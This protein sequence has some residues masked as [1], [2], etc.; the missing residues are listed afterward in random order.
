MKTQ[1]AL[2]GDARTLDTLSRFLAQCEKLSPEPVAPP[3]AVQGEDR[4]VYVEAGYRTEE[5][6]FVAGD[7]MAT[8][9]ADIVEETGVL[10]ALAP[11]VARTVYDSV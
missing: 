6:T 4:V 5:E 8:A 2:T 9:G 1:L 3:K 7:H 10:S 11:F